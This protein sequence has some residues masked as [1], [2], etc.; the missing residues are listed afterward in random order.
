[1]F[2]CT[3]R[4]VKPRPLL[5]ASIQSPDSDG[6]AKFDPKSNA[7][8]NLAPK[9]YADLDLRCRLTLLSEAATKSQPSP[10]TT[11]GSR[12]WGT[13][14]PPFYRRAFCRKTQISVGVFSS[15]GGDDQMVGDADWFMPLRFWISNNWSDA[16]CEWSNKFDQRPQLIIRRQIARSS[17]DEVAR[18]SQTANGVD[19]QHLPCWICVGFIASPI[20]RM[21]S[22]GF[23]W[24]LL[25]EY[26]VMEQQ[27]L[28][29]AQRCWHLPRTAQ[30]PPSNWRL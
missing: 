6:G 17:P 16:G 26:E 24:R 5:S 29:F 27:D 21:D 1:M 12:W 14:S 11:L 2:I 7:E 19:R 9:S 18:K 25:V 10:I 15:L 28:F 23:K 22:D 20:V 4:V 30:R 8:Q 3:P 13:K